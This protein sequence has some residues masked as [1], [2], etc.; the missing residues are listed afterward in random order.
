MSK[1][2]NN[3]IENNVHIKSVILENFL[4]FKRDEV[5]F[6]NNKFV[7]LIG[8]NWSGKT[9]IFQAIKFALG[10]NERGDRYSKWSS[11]I[12]HGQDHAMAELHIQNNDE[13]IKIRRTVIKDRSPYFELKRE[14]DK[15][16]KEAKATEI[17]ELVD[18]LGYRVDNQFA[19][20]SQGK[21]DAL[22]DLKPPDLCNFLE[23]GIGL[24]GLRTEILQQKNNIE[25]LNTQLYSMRSK[26]KSL[27]I[28]LDLL[29]PKLERLKE[30]Q[31]LLEKKQKY[32]DELLYANRQKL[33]LE[34]VDLTEE[35]KKIKSQITQTKEK[36]KEISSQIQ[37]LD[38]KVEEYEKKLSE[39]SE[40]IGN[41]KYRKDELVDKINRWQK[42]K[43][44]R[45]DELDELAGKIKKLHKKLDNQQN[46]KES[47]VSDLEVIKKERNKIE[48]EIE[49]LI[50][51]QAE[52]SEKVEKNKQFLEKYNQLVKERNEKQE[53]IE[54]NLAT[55]EDLES[56]INQLFA[57]Y[58]DINH[59]LE[60]NKWFLE[61]PTK[62]LLSELDKKLR[63][64][65]SKLYD[66]EEEIKRLKYKKSNKLE[67][68]K[69][70]QKN[71]SERRV[72]L[73]TQIN[74]LKN[75]IEKRGLDAKGPI[76][77][78]IQYDDKLS[79]AIESVLGERLLYSF[80]ADDWKTM[81]LLKRLKNK[82]NAYCNIY[83][84]KK[85]SVRSFREFN[86]KGVVG[87][88]AELIKTKDPDIKKIIYSKIKNC[89]VVENYR[90]GEDLYKVHDFKGKCVTL[91]GEQIISYKY[92]YETPYVKKLK[93]LLSAGTQKEQA[94]KLEEKIKQMD[95]KISELKVK[96]SK[97]DDKQRELYNKKESFNDLL[98]Q[99]KQKKRITEKKNR[100]YE[101]K[102]E[103]ERI[104]TKLQSEI[105]NLNAKINEF[106]DKKDPNFFK[107]NERINEIPK[108]L[109]ELNQKKKKWNENYNEKN[110]ILKA[111]EQKINKTENKVN[112]IEAEH[113]TK[114]E[115]FQ[116][117][118]RNAF[119]LYRELDDIEETISELKEEFKE[120]TGK[121]NEILEQ[122]GQLNKKNVELKFKL[123]DKKTKL[124]RKE[125]ELATR[126]QDLER[127]DKEI[128]E[129][130]EKKETEP[131][132]VED[133]KDDLKDIEKELL[134]YYDVDDSLLVEKER[135]LSSLKKITEKQ[136]EL[137]DEIKAAI[138][139]ENKLEDTYFEKFQSHLGQLESKINSKF[140][141][142]DINIYCKIELIGNFQD[143]G[144]DI[145]A[146]TSNKPLVSCTAL[147]GG[148]VSIL[149]IALILSLQEMQ[150]SPLCMFDEAAMFLD[151]RNTEITYQLIKSTLEQN[152]TQMFFFLPKSSNPLFR[153][154]D[155]LIGVA[156]VG[157]DE[158]SA[159]FDPPKFEDVAEESNYNE[160]D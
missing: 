8:P 107:W 31:K 138:D 96:A 23:E 28:S 50:Q 160:E 106:E 126:N 90:H 36:K 93:G 136:G 84:P 82:Y 59:K 128:G 158:V 121:K 18:R 6:G 112:L 62:N 10:S 111:V 16:F 33:L 64:T 17:H 154:A 76:I 145:K 88:L 5:R 80:V 151:D 81:S 57:S 30:K 39:I 58:N 127:I 105:K 129:K 134:K 32:E 71:L 115:E 144:V 150:P 153:L 74:I 101:R 37:E 110:S 54:Q 20:V 2:A 68:F 22:K 85:Q 117:I 99:F 14:D 12:R 122:K 26:K 9:S 148:Q 109:Q 130:V 47:V 103:L 43:V 83:V 116:K 52:L 132:S 24:K 53:K 44:D 72:V 70:L 56:Q 25:E 65:S 91:D 133:I 7:I 77:E 15:D 92:A 100:L 135:I 3:N 124:N 140:E 142:T 46:Q 29:R 95:D 102:G 113:Q 45:K 94:D 1:I 131:R 119:K 42:E 41:K 97:L 79:Y 27:N 137:K 35:I 155:K 60:K 13:L 152:P 156:R 38:N 49:D 98:Y 21:I 73:P 114:K 89:L 69:Q 55:M 61:N 120:Y 123:D 34:I 146:A 4:S 104:N 67:D 86:A 51:E 78:Y 159:I 118:D 75:E 125:D 149:S 19:F 40:K 139:T 66:L 141:E 147:S 63:K 157:R 87:Y 48:D 108:L 11:F 143:L